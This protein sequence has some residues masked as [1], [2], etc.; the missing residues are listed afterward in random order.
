MYF[1]PFLFIIWISAHLAAGSL[2]TRTTLW[3]GCEFA[4]FSVV[5]FTLGNNIN[6]ELRYFSNLSPNSLCQLPGV[7]K[8]T[9]VFMA[10]VSLWT[11]AEQTESVLWNFSLSK[12]AT[13]ETHLTYQ[14]RE[15]SQGGAKRLKILINIFCDC[16][17]VFTSC[18]S[19]ESRHVCMSVSIGEHM[20]NQVFNE[21]P[22]WQ[23]HLQWNMSC[24]LGLAEKGWQGRDAKREQTIGP[25]SPSSPSCPSRLPH[26]AENSATF[27]AEVWSNS[28][29]QCPCLYL[30]GRLQL[31]TAS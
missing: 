4:S 12:G 14:G 21:W 6:L 18:C 19:V 24:V 30:M 2:L 9:N 13:V 27:W 10:V 17:C 5:I 16:T 28:L 7:F 11:K 22:D 25:A 1:K 20:E 3:V 29:P 23:R 31:I 15:K 8:R 26:Q